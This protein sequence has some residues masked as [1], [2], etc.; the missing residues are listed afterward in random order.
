MNIKDTLDEIGILET[1]MQIEKYM[2]D[3]SLLNSILSEMPIPT[4]NE[5]KEIINNTLNKI[6]GL[7]KKNIFLLSNEIALIEQF[8]LHKDK[9]ENII[10]CLSRNLS[11][12][13]KKI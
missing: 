12:E 10:V 1:N 4:R 6:L 5:T 9:I 2:D 11:Y 7:N 13:Q 8:V 3:K